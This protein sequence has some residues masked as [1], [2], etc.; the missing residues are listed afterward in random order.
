MPLINQLG[1]G[2]KRIHL[3]TDASAAKAMSQRTSVPTRAKHMSVRFLYLQHLVRTK[4]IIPMKIS[5]HGN[6]SDIVTKHVNRD[7]LERLRLG[8]CLFSEE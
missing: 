2:I 4:D 3:S 8:F 5:T 6:R 1:M 7:V